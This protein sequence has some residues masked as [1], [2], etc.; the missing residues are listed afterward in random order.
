MG[1]SI[2]AVLKGRDVPYV[3]IHFCA[4]VSCSRLDTQKAG[5]VWYMNDELKNLYYSNILLIKDVSSVV[6]CFRLQ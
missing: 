2:L 6:F 3:N 1:L 4:V 5:Q